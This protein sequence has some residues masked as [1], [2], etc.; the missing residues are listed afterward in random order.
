MLRALSSRALRRASPKRARAEL[1]VRPDRGVETVANRQRRHDRCRHREAGRHAGSKAYIYT[2]LRVSGAA[3]RRSWRP[4]PQVS[5]T[6][7]QLAAR[8]LAPVCSVSSTERLQQPGA[9]AIQTLAVVAD[10]GRPGPARAR[11]GCDTQCRGAPQPAQSQ[12][13]VQVRAPARVVPPDPGVAGPQPPRTR[14]EPDAAAANHAPNPPDT[15]VAGRRTDRRR[16]GARTP[17]ACSRLGAARRSQPAPGSDPQPCRPC[18]ARP[19]PAPSGAEA[20]APGPQRREP[21][22]SQAARRGRPPAGRTTPGNSSR[23]PPAP[24]VA[25]IER[26][27]DAIGDRP[28]LRPLRN[29]LVQ[30]V[31]G[32][33]APVEYV[34]PDSECHAGRRSEVAAVQRT[35]ARQG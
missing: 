26:F 16:A 21:P 14:R 12:H 30:H 22:D 11:P 31:A 9:I 32:G 19:P 4:R 17:S 15:A 33:R 24:P 28:R 27:T 29:C 20:P 2:A 6:R 10:C 35:G 25:E 7:T 8:T 13:P 5:P 3:C 34:R 1:V 23:A 18:P